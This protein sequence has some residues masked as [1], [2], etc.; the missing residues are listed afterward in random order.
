LGSR[1][2]QKIDPAFADTLQQAFLKCREPLQKLLENYPEF[3]LE[4]G[5]EY[6]TWLLNGCGA[7]ATSEFLLGLAEYLKIDPRPELQDAAKKLAEGLLKMQQPTGAACA[8]AFLSWRQTWH[9]WGNAQ[10]G[11]LVELSQVLESPEFRVAAQREADTFFAGLIAQGWLN[12][13]R[14]EP[15]F[16]KQEFPQIAYGVRGMTVGLLRLAEATGEIK[17]DQLAGLAASWLFGNNAAQTP[18][19]DA[20][21]GRCFDGIND[22]VSVNLNSGAE[23]TIEALLTLVE[24]SGCPAALRML[25]FRSVPTTPTSPARR[26]RLFRNPTS[27]KIALVLKPENS[28]FEIL[29]GAELDSFLLKN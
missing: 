20:V 23:S 14:F 16:E 7:D 28:G 10:S 1:V 5:R 21:T 25:D 24:L 19:Y 9:A 2:F 27:E 12:A 13:C 8:G 15:E 26:F 18:M 17:Y 29:F 22:S 11:A 6:P 4:N 3:E